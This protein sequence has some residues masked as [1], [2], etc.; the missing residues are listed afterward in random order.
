MALTDID[1]ESLFGSMLDPDEPAP[2]NTVKKGGKTSKGVKVATAPEVSAVKPEV[3][4]VEPNAAAKQFTLSSFK[5]HA[6]KKGMWAGALKP[7]TIPDLLGARLV[8]TDAL[9]DAL[10]DM[11]A[12]TPADA[13]ADALA[14]GETGLAAED[15]DSDVVALSEALDDAVAV[16][17][18][19]HAGGASKASS[20]A[21]ATRGGMAAR[22]AK[23]RA[24]VRRRRVV[25]LTGR[26]TRETGGAKRVAR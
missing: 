26:K 24:Q 25:F 22:R 6:K 11:L 3:A 9:A 5:D 14:D 16:G 20:T 13:L 4:A 10:A 2:A 15:A 1:L 7:V 18:C 23:W 12:D 21:K 8:L 17:D 19:A